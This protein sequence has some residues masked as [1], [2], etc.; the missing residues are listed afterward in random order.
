MIGERSSSIPVAYTDN[1]TD[2][3]TDARPNRDGRATI[4]ELA[5]PESTPFQVRD[6]GDIAA[7]IVAIQD[8]DVLVAQRRS[9]F[10]EST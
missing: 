9:R 6:V 7:V 2:P 4:C 1:R 5:V 3:E 10:Y 8:F